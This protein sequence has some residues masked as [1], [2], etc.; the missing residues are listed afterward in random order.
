LKS[1][2]KTKVALVCVIGN[3][4]AGVEIVIDGLIAEVRENAELFSVDSDQTSPVLEAG[5]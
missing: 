5:L 2:F 1:A 3:D 4:C